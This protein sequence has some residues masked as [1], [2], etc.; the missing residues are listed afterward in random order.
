MAPDRFD[1]DDNTVRDPCV[2][3][4]ADVTGHERGRAAHVA[5]IVGE[6][7]IRLHAAAVARIVARHRSPAGHDRT[8]AS[9][10]DER[11]GCPPRI[12]HRCRPSRARP[13]V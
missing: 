12:R 5:R 7:A 2:M 10:A 6:Y 8:P 3:R 4:L 13:R 11:M 1:A 9:R